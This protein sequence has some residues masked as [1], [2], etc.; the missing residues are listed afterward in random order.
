MNAAGRPRRVLIGL[1]LALGS[2]SCLCPARRLDYDSPEAVLASWQSQLCHAESADDMRLEYR[3]LAAS[4]KTRIR[5]F[6]TYVAARRN[7]LDSNP[8]A[9]N[10]LL[11]YGDLGAR[12]DERIERPD[13]RVSLLFRE[14]TASFAL[15]FERETWLIGE[16]DD[17]R[18][19]LTTRLDGSLAELLVQNGSDLWLSLQ[20]TRLGEDERLHLKS[21]DL[22]RRWKISS[23]DGLL[24]SSP[25]Q[26]PQP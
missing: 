6:E 8:L 26:D 1:V 15:S 20:R 5:G 18:P 25:P 17:G 3:C 2:V 11:K 22:E 23:V 13:G 7:L 24:A 14:G 19:P 21:V 16:Y 10:L 4:L 12:A 9:A